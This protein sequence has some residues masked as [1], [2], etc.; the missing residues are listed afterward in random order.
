MTKSGLVFGCNSASAQPNQTGYGIPQHFAAYPMLFEAGTVKEAIK[1]F[2]NI[3]F[4]G[5]GL[6]MG[7]ADAHGE[8][9]VIEK[10]GTTQ[11]VR[12]ID[13]DAALAVNLY[14][15]ENLMDF[16]ANMSKQYTQ[17]SLDRRDHFTNWKA[18]IGN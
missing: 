5:K 13:E 10:T 15:C 6:I 8:A 17:N 16:N 4:A 2:K 7:L 9:V 11:G 1:Y 14:E 18:K 3:D 12:W